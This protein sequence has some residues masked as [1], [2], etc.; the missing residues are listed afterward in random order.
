MDLDNYFK[1]KHIKNANVNY[2]Q[3]KE[4]TWNKDIDQQI[5]IK[6]MENLTEPFIIRN[7]YNSNAVNIWNKDNIGDIFGDFKFNIEVYNDKYDYYNGIKDCSKD[8]NLTVKQYLD[9][10]TDI[11]LKPPYYYLAEIDLKEKMYEDEAFLNAHIMPDIININEFTDISNSTFPVGETIYFGNNTT[12][13]CHMHVED[14]FVLNQVFG[15]KDIYIFDYY[16]TKNHHLFSMQSPF[17]GGNNFIS[18]NFFEQDHSLYND[19]YKVSLN[20]GDTLFIPPWWLHA[21]RGNNVN[22]SITKI[23]TRNDHSYL[24]NDLYLLLLYTV[25]YLENF[26][27]YYGINILFVLVFCFIIFY[28]YYYYNYII[29]IF[30]IYK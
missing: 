4:Y 3:L 17:S 16:N 1:N 27:Q 10:M 11:N 20:P 2:K 23:Y 30:N 28:C 9:Y 22:C 15:T 6:K 12:S 25:K 18:E 26:C 21:V 24:Y 7:Y 13:G 14:D 5:V 8:L 19:L 29:S